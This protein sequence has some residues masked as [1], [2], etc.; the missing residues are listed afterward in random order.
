MVSNHFF[1]LEVILL[2]PQNFTLI[3]TSTELILSSA[4]WVILGISGRKRPPT[5]ST[6]VSENSTINGYFTTSLQ[7]A[8]M[9]QE[10]QNTSSRH[11]KLRIHIRSTKDETVL[12][13]RKGQ[14]KITASIAR[15][16][17]TQSSLKNA[18]NRSQK[19][20]HEVQYGYWQHNLKENCLPGSKE[21][22][23]ESASE[24]TAGNCVCPMQP[25]ASA[26]HTFNV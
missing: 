5:P 9:H 21:V 25:G 24:N 11:N 13:Q 7:P 20:N 1:L 22:K 10:S 18:R 4:L 19:L 2:N 16:R 17:I 8:E 3:S 12:W 23:P 15:P 6:P 14:V 26:V